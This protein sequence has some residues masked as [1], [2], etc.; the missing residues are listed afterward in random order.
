MSVTP[1]LGPHTLYE[2]S[3]EYPYRVG[4]HSEVKVHQDVGQDVRQLADV[5][6]HAF[7]IEEVSNSLLE[8]TDIGVIDGEDSESVKINNQTEGSDNEFAS[9]VRKVFSTKAS[10]PS[11][12]RQ[13]RQKRIAHR[14]E[15]DL[16]GQAGLTQYFIRVVDMELQCRELG[17]LSLRARNEQIEHPKKFDADTFL[18]VRVCPFRRDM[19][20]SSAS[21]PASLLRTF[22][23]ISVSHFAK[24][25]RPCLESNWL[26]PSGMM[27]VA[28]DDIFV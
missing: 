26:S 6:I 2:M 11:A 22:A 1:R 19:R 12:T 20:R 24:L 4:H 14:V 8:M 3:A 21:C 9:F 23:A 7:Q 18:P 28:I 15:Q 17:Q 27:V 10:V 5:F 25:S 16:I 13:A